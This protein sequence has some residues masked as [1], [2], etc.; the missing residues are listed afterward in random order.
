MSPSITVGETLV[1]CGFYYYYF[2]LTNEFLKSFLIQ[3]QIDTE[4][5]ISFI[6]NPHLCE[7]YLML[8]LPSHL[9]MH[10]SGGN[11]NTYDKYLGRLDLKF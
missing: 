9:K 11:F 2:M 1:I 7:K 8:F 10:I 3:K 4:I 5:L 6:E